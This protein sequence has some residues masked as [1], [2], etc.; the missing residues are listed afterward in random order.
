MSFHQYADDNQL[1][2]TFACNDDAELNS[3]VFR[4]DPCLADITNWMTCNKL[5]LNPDKTDFL[6]LNQKY[7]HA[8]APRLFKQSK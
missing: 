7:M 1:Y 4:M 2:T 6:I 5:I 8:A 3:V